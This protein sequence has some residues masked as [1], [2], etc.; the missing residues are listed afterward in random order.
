MIRYILFRI[1]IDEAWHKGIIHTYM[2]GAAVVEHA[3]TSELHS[4]IVSPTMLKF[5]MSM[6]D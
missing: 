3:A 4:V 2:N 1:G 6:A 5:E